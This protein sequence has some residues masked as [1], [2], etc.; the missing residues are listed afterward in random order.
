MRIR[1]HHE[2]TY[3]YQAPLKYSVMIVRLSPQSG[4]E[5]HVLD[6]RVEAPGHLAPFRD[7]HGNRAMCL[8]LG[9]AHEEVTVIARGLVETVETHGVRPRARWCRPSKREAAISAR[10]LSAKATNRRSSWVWGPGRR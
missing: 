3:R 9:E 10:K 2:T 8:F 6:W 5:Q 1:V 4:P 7:H